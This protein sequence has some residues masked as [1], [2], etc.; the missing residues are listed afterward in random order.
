MAIDYINQA[1]QHRTRE[2]W[3]ELEYELGHCHIQVSCHYLLIIASSWGPVMPHIVNATYTLLQNTA[4]C[5]QGTNLITW[6]TCVCCYTH[7]HTQGATWH[8]VLVEKDQAA[9]YQLHCRP[10]SAPAPHLLLI[11]AIVSI[12]VRWTDILL[13]WLIWW[14]TVISL[15]YFAASLSVCL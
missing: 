2:V 4:Q 5:Y 15:H 9:F 7:F 11:Q 14:T 3:G 13:C 8:S 6:L 10:L 12:S 1:L